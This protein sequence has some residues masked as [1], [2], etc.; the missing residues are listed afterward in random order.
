MLTISR[1]VAIT[2][3]ASL[4]SGIIESIGIL[5][6]L[7]H[8]MAMNPACGR[9]ASPIGAFTL[10]ELL[11]V[12]AI[13]AILASMLLPALSRAKQKARAINCVSNLKQWGLA[14]A[15][16]TED[17]GGRF[18]QGID[19][20]GG[21]STGGGWL[22][23][24]WMLA[25]KKHYVRKPHLLLCPS[26]TRRRA[27]DPVRERLFGGSG[28]P[29]AYGGAF[30]AYDFPVN[31]PE[32]TGGSGNMKLI[33]GSYA[34]NNYIYDPPPGVN[35]IQ[36]RPVSRNWRRIEAARQPSLTPLMADAMWRGGGPH[37]TLRAAAAN[38]RWNDYDQEFQHFAMH[39]HAKGINLLCFDNS[40]R[41]SRA[42][43]LWS[44]PWNRE[45]DT[46]RMHQ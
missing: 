27:Q 30:T 8:H 2:G 17:N 34:C 5:D 9:R 7:L 32:L 28:A 36:G 39:R 13:I 37:H 43:M 35:N 12:I 29:A 21:G 18:S 16:Y 14:W 45:F 33:A 31:D 1:G 22:R 4:I 23:G 24:E 42:R 15:I 44:M 20:T 40:V 41:Y 19:T 38:G 3:G 26:A 10:I 25:L 46:C 6:H 11:V